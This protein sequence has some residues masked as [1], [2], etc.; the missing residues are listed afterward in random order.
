MVETAAP[1]TTTIGLALWEKF[2]KPYLFPAKSD[3]IV[4]LYDTSGFA[5]TIN[6]AIK[7]YKR[8]K[9]VY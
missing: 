4:I 7:G 6:F 3:I 9:M 2:D 5:N 1:L 8:E